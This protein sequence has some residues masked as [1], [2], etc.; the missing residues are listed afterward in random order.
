M[1]RRAALLALAVVSTSACVGARSGAPLAGVNTG[2]LTTLAATVSFDHGCPAER[3]RVIRMAPPYEGYGGA[4]VDVCGVV[5]RYKRFGAHGSF[6]TWLD[7]TSLYPA[8]ALPPPLPPAE[9]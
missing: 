4:D 8:S 7:V 1:S 6:D 9:R 3:I 5:R 2:P